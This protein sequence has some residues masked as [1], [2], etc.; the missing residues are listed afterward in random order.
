MELEHGLVEE[1]ETEKKSKHDDDDD[2]NSELDP[3]RFSSDQYG[4]KVFTVLNVQGGNFGC[5]NSCKTDDEKLIEVWH[6]TRS[7]NYSKSGKDN[8]IDLKSKLTLPLD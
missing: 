4:G 3:K 5:M 1:P 6:S 7:L 8:I 2:K